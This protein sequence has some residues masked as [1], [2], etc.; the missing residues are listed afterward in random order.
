M[1]SKIEECFSDKI[2]FTRP[3]GGLFIWC[4]LPE[5]ADMPSFCK[6]A[7]SE[8]K[9]AVV[10]GNDFFEGSPED[11]RYI[12]LNFSKPNID[13]INY[14]IEKLGELTYQYCK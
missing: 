2:S 12:R 8:Y 11:C 4:T 9:I 6:K 3:Q 14:G 7:V 10:P 1:I 5:N 13:D